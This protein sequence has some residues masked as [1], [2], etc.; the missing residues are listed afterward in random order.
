MIRLFGGMH[1][2]DP[3]HFFRRLGRGDV[4][5]EDDRFLSASH[6]HTFERFIDACV[7]LLMRNERRDVDEVAGPRFSGELQSISPAHARFAL[8][9]I[10]YTFELA[11]MMRAGFG[12]RMNADRAGPKLRS[13]G[14]SVSDCRGSVHAGSLR[15]VRVELAGAH[16]ANA[17]K[18]PVDF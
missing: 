10:D 5:I 18:L 7:D 16:D 1:V 4:E 13:A 2:V 9:D 11:V 14:S 15:S 3:A 6:E 17:V 8:Y 12:V